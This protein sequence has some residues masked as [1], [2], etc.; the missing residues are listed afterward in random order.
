MNL[1]K[2]KELYIILKNN[3]IDFCLNN[4]LS[5][6]LKLKKIDKQLTIVDISKV[7]EFVPILDIKKE[8]VFIN[9]GNKNIDQAFKL[10]FDTLN[11]YF[12]E[13]TLKNLYNNIIWV[14]YEE[15]FFLLWSGDYDTFENKIR[16][17]LDSNVDTLTHELLHLASNPYDGK[18]IHSG[19]QQEIDNYFIGYGLDEG[20][21]EYLNNRYFKAKTLSVYDD[22]ITTCKYLEDII[23]QK[24]MEKMYF[25]GSLFG[26]IKHLKQYYSVREIERFITAV[27]FTH[28]YSDKYFLSNIESEVLYSQFETIISFLF[29]G[30]LY[31]FKN[32]DI[33][34]HQIKEITYSYIKNLINE[35]VFEIDEFLVEEL[36]LI[37]EEILNKFVKLDINNFKDK[38]IVL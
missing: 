8:N 17:A 31:K 20:Y 5:N 24:E 10:F 38:E 37:I 16:V 12:D 22:Q 25:N 26:L 23:G 6:K 28:D 3:M 32:T 11:K 4:K 15:R 2:F 19:F 36:E 33:T 34:E 13:D 30:Y 35:F 14:K 1:S 7:K 29:K 27:D 9:T 21:T 18:S